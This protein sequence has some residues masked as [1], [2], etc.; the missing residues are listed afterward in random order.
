M[1]EFM[2]DVDPL[3]DRL[4]FG[5]NDSEDFR[6]EVIHYLKSRGKLDI[7]IPLPQTN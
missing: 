5:Y 3:L 7:E 2:E 4:H 1:K 6:K